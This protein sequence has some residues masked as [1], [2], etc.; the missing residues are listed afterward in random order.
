M[1]VVRDQG[2]L[3]AGLLG[4]ARA[5]DELTRR[6]LLRRQRVADPRHGV[7]ASPTPKAE[8]GSGTSAL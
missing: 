6:A 5:L 1:E 2:E 4:G 8:T 7:S 3:E